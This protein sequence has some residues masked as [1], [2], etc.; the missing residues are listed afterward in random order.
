MNLFDAWMERRT[1][2]HART[3][4]IA[5]ELAVPEGALLA[6]APPLGAA[7]AVTTG[8][9][10][11]GPAAIVAALAEGVH[12]Q[13]LTRN[14]TAVLEVDGAYGENSFFAEAG[15]GQSLGAIE[16]RYVARAVREIFRVDEETAHGLRRS[17]QWVAAD[18]TV[19]H[20][21]FAKDEAAAARL[22]QFPLHEQA[23]VA[24]APVAG[25][26]APLTPPVDVDALR[27]AWSA[28]QDTHDFFPMLRRLNVRRIDA[29]RAVG[30]PFVDPLP[31]FALQELLEALATSQDPFLIFVQNRAVTQVAH[32]PIARVVPMGDRWLNILDPGLSLHVANPATLTC[33]RVRKPTKLG[34]IVALEAYA[35]DGE[36]AVLVVGDRKEGAPPDPRVRAAIEALAG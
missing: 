14:A 36:L 8:R 26:P 23:N 31:A 33:F 30:A 6:A 35:P 9:L 19:V 3:Y 16:L 2:P 15:L 4:D 5:A 32:G 24:F 27:A 7:Q 29:V 25:G 12:L 34:E 1:R 17:L 20:K 21:A 22:G 11:D 28:L 18:G 10:L 13:G